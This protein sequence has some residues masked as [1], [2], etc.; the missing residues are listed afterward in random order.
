[1]LLLAFSVVGAEELPE[2]PVVSP[3]RTA[4]NSARDLVAVGKSDEAMKVLQEL[5][6]SGFTAVSVITGDSTLSALAGR[7]DFDDTRGRLPAL[8]RPART[9]RPIRLRRPRQGAALLR[10]A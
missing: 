9:R 5:A 1:M 4:L 3:A 2:A 10:K 7:P 6:D 8:R